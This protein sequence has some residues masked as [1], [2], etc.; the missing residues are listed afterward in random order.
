M[1]QF[2]SKTARSAWLFA[3]AFPPSLL[4]LQ[5]TQDRVN[6]TDET[7]LEG[8]IKSEDYEGVS[9]QVDNATK[10]V[11]WDT[12]ASITYSDG[13]LLANAIDAYGGSRFDESLAQLDQL[14]ETDPPPRPVLA[15]QALFFRGLSQA[16]LGDLDAATATLQDLIGRFPKGRHLR[17]ATGALIDCALAKGDSAGASAALEKVLADTKGLEPFQKESALLKGRLLETQKK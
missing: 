8:E 1:K 11:S 3:L 4:P 16:R 6:L 17:A 2:R 15:Q 9:I 5:D 10:T 12:V 13:E 14:L 7:S